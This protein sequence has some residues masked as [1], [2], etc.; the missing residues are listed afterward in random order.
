MIVVPK[1]ADE[2]RDAILRAAASGERV[3][4]WD[5]AAVSGIVEYTPEDLTVTVRAG[6][7]LGELRAVLAGHGQWLPLD[8]PGGDGLTIERLVA[9]A[10]S[11]PRRAG[12]GT[13]RDWL[14][15]VRAV[16]GDGRV[17]MSGGRVVKNVAGFDVMKLFVG[18]HGSL[19]IVF[20]ATFK[21]A[22]LPE[23]E[24]F[25]RRACRDWV[26]L[27]GNADAVSAWRVVPTVFDAFRAAPREGV[28][29]VL[30]FAGGV[31]EVAANVARA[32]NAGW[33]EG[34]N[35]GHDARLRGGLPERLSVLPSNLAR[36]LGRLE[37]AAFVA[38]MANGIAYLPAGSVN[39]PGKSAATR[40]LE[41]RLKSRFDPSGILPAVP[42]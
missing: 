9:L 12:C 26:E 21:V 22:P 35:A 28:E 14:L 41:E 37:P 3:E 34:G 33:T 16:L 36:E 29:M 2:L 19:G 5:L 4:G 11:G 18:G 31:E 39:A 27:A 15:G 32:V 23:A 10:A 25:V 7:A 24:R 40:M 20:E 38:R 30:G 8:P 17:A 6:T 13:V 1:T 42:A